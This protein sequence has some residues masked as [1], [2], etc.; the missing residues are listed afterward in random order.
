[1]HAYLGIFWC[2]THF[3]YSGS[4]NILQLIAVCSQHQCL[5]LEPYQDLY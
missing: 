1:M 3:I 2:N 4:E 5:R